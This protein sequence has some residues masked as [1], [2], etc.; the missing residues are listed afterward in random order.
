MRVTRLQVNNWRNLESLDLSVPVEASLV[1]LVGEN[2]TGKSNVLQLL[3]A[4]ANQL[5]LAH[6]V[7][8]PRGNPLNDEHSVRV[9]A[10]INERPEVFFEL[11]QESESPS[12]GWSGKVEVR[13]E[14]Q[15]D[16][17][18]NISSVLALDVPSEHSQLIGA[19]TVQAYRN[20]RETCHLYL[21]SD[22]AYPSNVVNYQEFAQA[23][24]QEYGEPAFDRQFS[25]RPSRTMYS[26]WIKYMLSVEQQASTELTRQTRDAQRHGET[27]P[28]FL[29]PFV[30]YAES[31]T[32]VLPHLR[33]QGVDSKKRTLLFDVGGRTLPFDHLSGGEREIA[34]LLGQIDRF[35]LRR[36]LLLIDEPELH[37]N[38]DLLRLW[39]S[40]LRDTVENGQVW[41]ATHSLEAAEVAGAEATFVLH[42]DPAT[43]TVRRSESLEDAPALALLSAAVGSPAFSLHRTRFVLVEGDRQN[44]ERA[45][46]HE[47]CGEDALHR[48]MEVGNCVEVLRRLDVLRDLATDLDYPLIVGG[49]VDRDFRSDTEISNLEAESGVHVLRCDEVEN[50]FLQPEAISRIAEENGIRESPEDL[51]RDASDRFAGTWALRYAAAHTAS[52]EPSD[53]SMRRAAN[54]ESW[55]RV[56]IDPQAAATRIASSRSD[57]DAEEMDSWSTALQTAFELYAETRLRDDLWTECL[58]KEC[59]RTV[60]RLVGLSGPTYLEQRVR[61]LWTSGVVTMPHEAQLIK[62]YVAGLTAL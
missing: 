53:S 60:P 1:C 16:G 8:M 39:L 7:D 45:R 23:L 21:D 14:R 33:F 59:L 56:E 31:V 10:D 2:G 57:P 4:V 50:L 43:L 58:G 3:S 42:R 20:R 18:T 12:R 36:G 13:S 26:E 48:F 25:F 35:K 38:P 46:F 62:D 27:A 17:T 11:D 55:G 28:P 52:L 61:S 30:G 9:I 24:E 29:D 22:R 15:D 32:N 54:E 44:R 34:F 19:S 5:G 47:I 49:I 51:I 40:Y 37:L 41:I 6:G